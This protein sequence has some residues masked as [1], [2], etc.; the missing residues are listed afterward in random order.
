MSWFQHLEIC[1]LFDMLVVAYLW[2]RTTSRLLQDITQQVLCC[3][4]TNKPLGR[5]SW[6]PLVQ[7]EPLK[8]ALNMK[9]TRRFVFWCWPILE[10]HV[11]VVSCL[12]MTLVQRTGICVASAQWK[13]CEK[14]TERDSTDSFMQVMFHLRTPFLKSQHVLFGTQTWKKSTIHL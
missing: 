10:C 7:I 9:V 2:C 3:T 6:R 14:D 13:V 12:W 5:K 1:Y 8:T 11:V 4:P